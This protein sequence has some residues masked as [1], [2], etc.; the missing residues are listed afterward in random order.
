MVDGSELKAIIHASIIIRF[1]DD[2]LLSMLLFLIHNLRQQLPSKFSS[3]GR[4]L[5]SFTF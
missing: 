2:Y 5:P 4:S 1:H 3:Y